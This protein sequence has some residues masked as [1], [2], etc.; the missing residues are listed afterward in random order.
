MTIGMAILKYH[1]EMWIKF[2]SHIS[3]YRLDRIS[4]FKYFSNADSTI[5]TRR[6]K[7]NTRNC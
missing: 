3:C 1:I 2:L 4:N 5:V 6:A 7:A